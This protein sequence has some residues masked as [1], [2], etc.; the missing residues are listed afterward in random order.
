MKRVVNLEYLHSGLKTPAL[1]LVSIKWRGQ[2][3]LADNILGSKEWFD[4]DLWTYMYDLNINRDHH[5]GQPL[6]QVW[7]IDQVK[8][9]NDIERTT[10][11][12]QTER[13]TTNR[14]TD[15]CKTICPFFKGGKKWKVHVVK[16]FILNNNKNIYLQL[17]RYYR[18]QFWSL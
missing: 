18:S 3:I 7:G 9:S 17:S 13:L 4:L 6:Q 5:W 10:L 15:S 8:G 16:D 12:L 2:K 1:S 11:D 14:P